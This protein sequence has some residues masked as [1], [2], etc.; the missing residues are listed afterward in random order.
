MTNI[1]QESL[2]TNGKRSIPLH[3]KI[4][5]GLVAGA[6]VGVTAN[7]TFGAANVEGIVK[8]FTEPLGR[9]WL[10]ALIM[11][12]IPLILSTLSLGV[13]G[14][15][16]LKK[17]G[18]IGL[19]TMLSFLSLTA[20]AT[21]VG[22]VSMNV[23]HPGGGLDPAVRTQLMDAFK[24]QAQGAMGLAEGGFS[25]DIFVRM[26]PRNPVQ[27]MANGEMLAVIVFALAL[28][29]A[30]TLITRER[31]EPMIRFL[32][33]LAHI[34]VAI[35]GIVMKVAPIGVFFLIFG[36]T[37]RF[38]YDLLLS[39]LAYVATIIGGLAVVL[40]VVYPVILKF[41][42][43]RNPMDFMR[44]VR[45]VMLTA[46]STSSS[47]ATLP[48]TIRVAQE[49]L[50]IPREVS[51]FVIPLGATMNMNGTALF[52]GGTVLFL[53]QVFGVN[54]SIGAQLV[55]VLMSVVTAIGTA[56]VPGGSIPLLM[57]VLGMVGVPM[58][59]IAIIIGVD[60]ILDM[61]R[62]V[63]NVTGDVITASIVDRFEGSRAANAATK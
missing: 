41:I 19:I 45:V 31:A 48:T 8:N 37:A 13:A 28:G 42:A 30:L 4:L 18:R 33:S 62:T 20:V 25:V 53:A 22:L 52:E 12:V 23:I 38:G 44:K 46:F 63:V 14:L 40:V 6:A 32:E 36:V 3:S 10:N 35:I 49:D 1:E 26:I 54:L 55:V 34:V 59:G 61:S 27:A 47:N 50:R 29:V 11:V 60:R 15:G 17:L 9:M 51:G 43:R 24:G 16:D 39:L 5:I 56:G 57:M 2:A 58:E 21:T 7:L